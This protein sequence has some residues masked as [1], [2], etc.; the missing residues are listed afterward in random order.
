MVEQE[1]VRYQAYRESIR[2]LQES[3]S[4]GHPAFSPDEIQAL[5]ERGCPFEARRIK[6][7]R[8]PSRKCL[9]IAYEQL[10]KHPDWSLWMGFVLGSGGWSAHAWNMTPHEVVV[11][12]NAR[13]RPELYY[14]TEY[15]AGP[16]SLKRRG[17]TDEEIRKF[18]TYTTH[19][20]REIR[21]R[22]KTKA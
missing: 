11:E 7:I 21:R 8:G 12:P 22:E 3:I 20:V 13:E 5:L 2:Q 19:F 9:E 14:G 6:Y 1:E 17:F 10:R 15:L 4:K 16:K 18:D